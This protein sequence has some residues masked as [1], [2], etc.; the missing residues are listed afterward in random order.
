M[1]RR[2]ALVLLFCSAL[3]PGALAL[4]GFDSNNPECRSK[5]PVCTDPSKCP[6]LTVDGSRAQSSYYVVI[7]EFSETSCAVVEGCTQPGKR[8][9]LR[10]DMSTPNIGT[11]DLHLGDPSKADMKSC[12][13]WSPCHAHYHFTAYADFALI[14]PKAQ[15]DGETVVARGAKSSSCLMDGY[16]IP[17][18]NDSPI[19]QQGQIYTCQNQGIH[20]GY[21]DLY[22][23]HLDCQWIDV[24]GLTP[25]TYTM[26]LEV[27]KYHVLPESNYNNNLVEVPVVVPADEDLPP[28]ANPSACPQQGSCSACANTRGCG[29]CASMGYCAYGNYLGPATGSCSKWVWSAA[30]CESLPPPGEVPETVRTCPN[31]TD[32]ASCTNSPGCGWCAATHKCS[33]GTTTGPL[34]ESGAS[35]TNGWTFG[36]SQQCDIDTCPEQ[37]SCE[38]CCNTPRC[39]WCRS[40]GTCSRGTLNGPSDNSCTADSWKWGLPQCVVV[41]PK[42]NCKGSDLTIP[43]LGM[44]GECP[45]GDNELA[46]GSHCLL[47]CPPG[48]LQSPGS[49][50]Q[51]CDD[52]T[53]SGAALQCTPD[54][55][56]VPAPPLGTNIGCAIGTR[57]P[58]G[59]SFTYGIKSGYKLKSGSL[60]RTCFAGAYDTAAPEMELLYPPPPATPTTQSMVATTPT[61]EAAPASEA[62]AAVVPVVTRNMMAVNHGYS[63]RSHVTVVLDAEAS[64]E[65]VSAVTTAEAPAPSTTEEAPA[66]PVASSKNGGATLVA[67]STTRAQCSAATSCSSCAKLAGCGWC[68]DSGICTDGSWTGAAVSSNSSCA[69]RDS[70]AWSML[71]CLPPPPSAEVS[72]NQASGQC[73]ACAS[74]RGC[75][76]CATT[77]KCVAGTWTGPLSQANRDSCPSYVWS[78]AT[79]STVDALDA[80]SNPSFADLLANNQLGAQ[81]QASLQHGDASA[82]ASLRPGLLLGERLEE[83]LTSLRVDLDDLLKADPAGNTFKQ[84]DPLDHL[85]KQDPEGTFLKTKRFK[86]VDLD[87]LPKLHHKPRRGPKPPKTGRTRAAA[88]PDAEDVP[89]DLFPRAIPD[90]WDPSPFDPRLPHG[91]TEHVHT[92]MGQNDEAPPGLQYSEPPTDAAAAAA[93]VSMDMAHD[94]SNGQ[95]MGHV[96]HGID[97]AA[98]RL[99]LSTN[100]GAMCNGVDEPQ[101][102]PPVS[103]SS[104]SSTGAAEEESS[105]SSSSSTGEDASSSTG[106]ENGSTGDD[107]PSSSSSSTGGVVDDDSSSSS[108]S[109]SSSGGNDGVDGGGLTGPSRP[110]SSAAALRPKVAAVLALALSVALALRA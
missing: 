13:I 82:L 26:R 69:T 48:Y 88:A 17:D 4:P 87:R 54:S 106:E 44:P 19:L 75:G 57:I 61:E 79:C 92:H 101:P 59:A 91:H 33:A 93:T 50:R 20:K 43:A 32:C 110:A 7:N 109:S 25:G 40:T 100:A 98:R 8:K 105:S 31:K 94:A 74:L 22:G 3:L 10:F 62:E 72:C 41:I 73:S 21:L 104:S 53:W 97:H 42:K 49:G 67:K 28:P 85:L 15:G 89:M 34:Q 86:H 30:T 37:Q 71:D 6:D 24:T 35:C 83:S 38:D 5:M 77:Q 66:M 46:S 36:S 18:P 51:T 12:F 65:P 11:A 90:K 47:A 107:D 39:G 68:A 16:R 1:L 9:L 96:S 103:S 56:I 102:E 55:C 45:T 58:S 76:W 84:D 64:V 108:S 2:L 63:A 80:A 52:G 29:W 27:N 60:T 70:W 95:S 14:D 23:G 99:L 81:V 78:A